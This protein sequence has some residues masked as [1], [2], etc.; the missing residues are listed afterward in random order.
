M[1]KLEYTVVSEIGLE[2]FIPKV[3][4]L[5]ENGWKPIGGICHVSTVI[6]STEGSGIVMDY[7]QALTR[8]LIKV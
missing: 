1:N 4:E 3:N 5:I 6:P 8:E 7:T 2:N